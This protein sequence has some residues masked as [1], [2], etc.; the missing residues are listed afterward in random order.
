MGF[1]L[2]EILFVFVSGLAKSA[3][4]LAARL[5][6]AGLILNLRATSA[7]LIFSLRTAR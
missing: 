3:P 2:P 7:Q 1:N 5:T 6:V 4:R